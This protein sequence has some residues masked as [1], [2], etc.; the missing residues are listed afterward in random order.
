MRRRSPRGRP[1]EPCGRA[2]LA[3][4]A[5]PR[6]RSALSPRSSASSPTGSRCASRTPIAVR[7]A[8][9][10]LLLVGDGD[11]RRRAGHGREDRVVQR[12][13]RPVGPL[14]RMHVG[15][16]DRAVLAARSVPAPSSTLCAI[17]TR[18]T[19]T[20]SPTS[21]ARSAIGPPSSPLANLS[22]AV[23]LLVVRLVVDQQHAPPV[24]GE[25][26]ARDV[27]DGRDRQAAHVLAARSCRGRSGRRRRSRSRP[28]PGPRRSSMGRGRRTSRPRAASPRG[29]SPQL[30]PWS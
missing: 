18:S 5:E 3:R 16:D 26:V 12:R 11:V 1:A 23:G 30:E 4:G 17:G 2:G 14:V 24:A 13:R 8:G 25:H 6:A 15:A 19:A 9:V 29:R 10:D 20:S 22:I 7:T 28:G 27:D 21:P